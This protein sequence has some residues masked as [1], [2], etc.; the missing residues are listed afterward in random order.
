MLSEIL[1]DDKPH[2]APFPD[3]DDVIRLEGVISGCELSVDPDSALFDE[4]SGLAVRPGEAIH[5]HSLDQ[6]QRESRLVD[7]VCWY[8]FGY[9][10]AAEPAVEVLRRPEGGLLP[11]L[12]SD[13][14]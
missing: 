5:H 1:L 6:P 11:L 12:P 9:L 2:P 10:S 7:A 13:Q 4:P 8:L 14:G 3:L